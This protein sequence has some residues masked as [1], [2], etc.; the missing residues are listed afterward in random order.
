[1][2]FTTYKIHRIYGKSGHFA[3]IFSPLSMNICHQTIKSQFVVFILY[4]VLFHLSNGANLNSI[5][6]KKKK[7]K[8]KTDAVI[9]EGFLHLP[10]NSEENLFCSIM[11]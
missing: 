1:M 5:E 10:S 8:K 6:K 3:I 4:Y 11:W 7:K 2:K 9:C